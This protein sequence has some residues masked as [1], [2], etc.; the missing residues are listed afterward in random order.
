[1]KREYASE[2]ASE[3][4]TR[5]RSRLGDRDR[6]VRNKTARRFHQLALAGSPP[7]DEERRIRDQ[8]CR[9]TA[10]ESLGGDSSSNRRDL[11][12]GK[13]T[14]SFAEIH[15]QAPSRPRDR[16][17]SRFSAESHQ[18]Y[19]KSPKSLRIC[20]WMFSGGGGGGDSRPSTPRTRPLRF[21]FDAFTE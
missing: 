13:S 10:E 1:M 6:V 2:R 19:D 21:R 20:G 18:R 4:D 11:D 5:P 9:I 15:T 14:R 7:A 16:D 12:D 8:R 17:L 3:R